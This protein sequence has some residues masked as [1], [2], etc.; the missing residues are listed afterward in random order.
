M[1]TDIECI[2]K[3]KNH[4]MLFDKKHVKKSLQEK[5][6]LADKHQQKPTLAK[7]PLY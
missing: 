2:L 3:Y 6:N 1:E 7:V 5:T 4:A